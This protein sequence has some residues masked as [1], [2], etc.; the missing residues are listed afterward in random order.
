[1]TTVLEAVST[2][3][4]ETR[5]LESDDKLHQLILKAA[6]KDAQAFSTLYEKYA[7]LMLGVA[8]SNARGRAVNEIDDIVQNVFLKFYEKE[9]AKFAEKMKAG[10]VKPER[11]RPLL[12]AATRNATLDANRKSGFRGSIESPMGAYDPKGKL[13]GKRLGEHAKKVVRAAY[14]R[15]LAKAKLSTEQRKFVMGLFGTT[16][17]KVPEDSGDIKKVAAKVWP[18][19]SEGSRKSLATRAKAR[20][21]QFFCKD[22]ELCK[23]LPHFKGELGMARKKSAQLAGLGK[24]NVCGKHACE[25][26][27]FL[28]ALGE[29]VTGIDQSQAQNLVLSWILENLPKD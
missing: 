17:F 11:L 29:D 14:K 9:F 15:A 28:A 3:L 12:L 23:L 10:K 13:K 6:E 2:F 25:E 20:F 27:E 24:G 19:S 5:L 22:E 4:E 18:D 7:K 21:L 1:M 8:R 26:I 16:D